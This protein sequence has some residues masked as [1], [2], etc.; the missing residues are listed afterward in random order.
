MRNKDMEFYISLLRHSRTVNET[1]HYHRHWFKRHF[2][3]MGK[4]A[5]QSTYTCGAH[6]VVLYKLYHIWAY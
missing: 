3:M 2:V 5:K 4:L 6:V 1:Y